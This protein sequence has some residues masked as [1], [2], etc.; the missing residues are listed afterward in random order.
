MC[1]GEESWAEGIVR[2]KV[3]RWNV[4]RVL[5]N[6]TEASMPG[7]ETVRIKRLEERCNRATGHGELCR[8]L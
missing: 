2:V 7:T 4:S 8:L 1:I 3:S 6:S 5:Q